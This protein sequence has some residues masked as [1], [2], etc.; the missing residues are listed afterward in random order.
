MDCNV[1]ILRQIF[2]LCLLYM[3]CVFFVQ[4]CIHTEKSI[5][6]IHKKWKILYVY[7]YTE[8]SHNTK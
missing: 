4:S 6:Y 2:V 5:Q 7:K 3:L 1:P 8:H